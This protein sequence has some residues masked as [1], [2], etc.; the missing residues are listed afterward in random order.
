[1]TS[2]AVLK[3]GRTGR[4]AAPHLEGRTRVDVEKSQSRMGLFNVASPARK[5]R[6]SANVE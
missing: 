3:F 5:G 6:E 2:G 1:L 4:V